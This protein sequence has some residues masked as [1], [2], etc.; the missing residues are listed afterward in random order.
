MLGNYLVT[1]WRNLVRQKL[2]GIINIAGLTMGLACAF[3]IALFLRDELSWESWIPDTQDVYRV[4]SVFSM[5]GRDHDFFNVTPFPVTPAM[6]ARIPEVMAQTHFTPEG[7]T[8]QIGDRQFPVTVAAVDPNFFQIFKLPFVQGDPAT[9]LGKPESVVLTEPIARK[10]FGAANPLGRTVILG[11]GHVLMVTGVLRALPHNTELFGDVVMP[12]NSKADTFPIPA[13]ASWLNVNGLGYVKLVPHADIRAVAAKLIPILDKSIDVKKEMG[14]DMRGSQLLQLPL[15]RFRDVHL[16]PFGRTEAGS[17]TTI[18]GFAVI[19]LL[20]VMI[21]C[22]NYMNLATARAMTRSREISLRKVMGAKRRQL[23]VQFTGESVLTAL[24]AWVLALTLVEVL[25]PSYDSFL[26]RPITYG[27]LTDWPLTLAFAVIAVLA[28]FLGGIY[29]AFVLSGFRHAARLG[30]AGSSGRSGLLRTSLVVLQFA[31]S[32]G[33]GIAMI[34]VFAQ[35]SYA[36]Q[37]DMGFNRHDL[38]VFG[39]RMD[40]ATRD[41]MAQALA[42]DPAIAGVARSTMTPL[43]GGIWVE[44]ITLPGHSEKLV[45]RN[46]SIDPDFITVYGMKLLAG[47]N[48]SRD[49]ALDAP[50]DPKAPRAGGEN[51][52]INAAAAR[53]FG[54][55]VQQ[56]IGRTFTVNDQTVVNQGL[57]TIVGVVADANFDG[58]RSATQPFI[59]NYDPKGMGTFTVRARPG[60]T[61]AA[62]AAIDRIWRRFVPKDAI[63]RRFEDDS[64]E[65][66]FAS[67]VRQGTIFAVFVCIAIFIA[68]LGLFGL[69]SFTAQRRTREIGLR[70]VFGARTGNVVRLLLWQFSLPVLL[71]NVIAWPVAWYYLHH[72]LEGY[73]YRIALSPLYFVAAGLIA[74]LISW[75]TV[76]AHTLLIARASPIHALRYE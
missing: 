47:R 45:I 1:A 34:V 24:V 75:A 51:V 13:R 66:L 68:C 54:F 36:R 18:Y 55:T 53:Q 28:G 16:A 63:Q 73:A 74:L 39:G 67:D 8:A 59:F 52:I 72:W 64:F 38:V 41:S 29:P 56:A 10:F 50:A 61:Q 35:I 60:Q 31:I 33:L 57:M 46:V 27:V 12:N 15:T 49:R 4:A 43:D 40:A 22:F 25:L 76:I 17:W 70:K 21:A 7:G 58:L 2:Y 11:D 23:I 19:A 44:S 65:R 37:I 71:A 6:Q 62:T 26:A 42:S 69:A 48:L 30:T 32:I 9:A 5:P 3:L 20:I 14:I